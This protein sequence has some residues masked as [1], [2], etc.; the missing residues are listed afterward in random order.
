MDRVFVIPLSYAFMER[1]MNPT[2]QRLYDLLSAEDP[3]HKKDPYISLPETYEEIPDWL[4][5]AIDPDF[6]VDKLL[7][8]FKQL[9]GLFDVVIVDTKGG[10]TAARMIYI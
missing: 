8:P 10:C 5:G 1:N 7:T 9:L 4:S 3:S 6:V 2:M